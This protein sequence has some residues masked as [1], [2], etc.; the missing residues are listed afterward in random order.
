LEINFSRDPYEPLEEWQCDV[1]ARL[2]TLAENR[3]RTDG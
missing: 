3:A 1:E 2:V